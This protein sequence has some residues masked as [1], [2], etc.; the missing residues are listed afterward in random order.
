MNA[1]YYL[2]GYPAL[3]FE[4]P[5]L[6]LQPP[7]LFLCH[8]RRTFSSGFP[9]PTT[10]MIFI[11]H[12]PVRDSDSCR[13]QG[14]PILSGVM[15]SA[16]VYLMQVFQGLQRRGHFCRNVV[17]MLAINSLTSPMV[18]FLPATITRMSGMCSF[19]LNISSPKA[20]KPP[21]PAATDALNRRECKTSHD[22]CHCDSH[23]VFWGW[24]PSL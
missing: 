9:E 7:Q 12:Y 22:D 24:L 4:A 17:G 1:Q 8:Q 3:G 2:W 18:S 20:N 11:L 14:R 21:S 16:R 15:S 13:Y 10:W 23:H 19:I 6:S 5:H